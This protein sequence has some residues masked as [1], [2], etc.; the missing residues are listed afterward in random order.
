MGFAELLLE[1]AISTSKKTMDEDEGLERDE[2]VLGF[3]EPARDFLGEKRDG[4][5][6]VRDEE[7]DLMHVLVINGAIIMTCGS[8]NCDLYAGK[9]MMLLVIVHDQ[10]FSNGGMVLH[11][12]KS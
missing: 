11:R 7:E 4:T 2:T 9:A 3:V 1:P 12:A 5:W 10:S 8:Q 6:G